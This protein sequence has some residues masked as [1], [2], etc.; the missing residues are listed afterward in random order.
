MHLTLEYMMGF[1]LFSDLEMYFY[2]KVKGQ[3]GR[4]AKRRYTGH[5]CIYVFI[6]VHDP[7]VSLLQEV[8]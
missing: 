6:G 1:G 3:M 5:Y 2:I 7:S 4:V 8:E